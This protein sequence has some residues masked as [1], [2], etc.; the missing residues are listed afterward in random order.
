MSVVCRSGMQ[1]EDF[2]GKRSG[3][4][5]EGLNADRSNER[6]STPPFDDANLTRRNFL[7]DDRRVGGDDAVRIQA[8]EHAS[9][10]G[11]QRSE[12][13]RMKMGLGLVDQRQAATLQRR[14]ETG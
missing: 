11:H 8:I 13:R 10:A 6:A 3:V 4:L 1:T 9:D 14:Y 5:T 12:Q 2:T 7:S